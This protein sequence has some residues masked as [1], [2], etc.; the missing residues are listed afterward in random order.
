M[1]KRNYQRRTAGPGRPRK[2][3]EDL[4]KFQAPTPGSTYDRLYA[5]KEK[6]GV[7]FSEL[8]TWLVDL[9]EGKIDEIELQ[10]KLKHQENYIQQLEK[11]KQALLEEREK[12]I[13]KIEKLEL[14]NQALKQGRSVRS[15][16]DARMLKALA[17]KAREGVSWK[18]LCAEVL[19]LRD[20]NKIKRLLKLAFVVKKDQHNRFPDRF[21]PKDIAREFQGWVLKRPGAKADIIDYILYREDTLKAAKGLAVG[22]AAREKVPEVK[23]LKSGKAAERWLEVFFEVVHREYMSLIDQKR[24]KDAK[25]YLEEKVPEKLEKVLAEIDPEDWRRAVLAVLEEHE[26]DWGDVFVSN[27]RRVVLRALNAYYAKPLEVTSNV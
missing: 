5:L 23:P 7:P 2:Y 21:Y 26:E 15:Y 25:K 19:G 16:Q 14:E 8:L 22:E 20:E 11:E 17:E 27:L 4:K 24:G 12:L 9:A 10:A 3:G 13:E 6:L 18:A 1:P